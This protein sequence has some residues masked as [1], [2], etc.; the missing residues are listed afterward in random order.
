MGLVYKHQRGLVKPKS[1]P[2]ERTA[3][4]PG[5]GIGSIKK[6]NMDILEHDRNREIE[7]KLVV[8]EDTLADQGY[9]DDEIAVKRDEA[10]KV[11]EASFD[12]DDYGFNMK[13]A[14]RPGVLVFFHF[15]FNL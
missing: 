2:L 5:L 4:K 11:L 9:M 13:E 12:L 1:V 8:L 3:Y 6:A 15:M 14:K 10:R 7:L